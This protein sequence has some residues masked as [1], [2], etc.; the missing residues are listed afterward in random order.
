[1]FDDALAQEEIL[2]PAPR[3]R[4]RRAFDDTGCGDSLAILELLARQVEL[5][6]AG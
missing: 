2:L 5:H 3:Q 1:M 6:T 4:P